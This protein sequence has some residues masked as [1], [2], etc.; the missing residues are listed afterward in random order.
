ML[1]DAYGFT[2]TDETD[3]KHCSTSNL[4]FLKTNKMSCPHGIT[5]SL[6]VTGEGLRA[7]SNTRELPVWTL[8]DGS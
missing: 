1:L 8:E 7:A 2:F 3:R 5:H 4:K 6:S